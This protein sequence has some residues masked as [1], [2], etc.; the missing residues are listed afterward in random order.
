MSSYNLSK[1]SRPLKQPSPI[2]LILF[3]DKSRRLRFVK[4]TNTFA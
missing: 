3:F 1:F 4:F 2:E